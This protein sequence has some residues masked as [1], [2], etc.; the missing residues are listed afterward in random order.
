MKKFTLFFI[1]I[2]LVALSFFVGVNDLTV[3]GLLE[4]V[5]Q[6]RL[7]FMTTRLPRTVSLV[8]AGATMSICGLVMQHLTQNKFVSPTTAGTMDS[9]RLGIVFVMLVLPSASTLTRGFV[10]FV[11]AL[12]GTLAFLFLSRYLPGKS[13]M[14]LP[15][16]GV[17]FG[18]IVG[19]VATFFAYQYQLVQNMSSWLQ[20]NFATVTR[21]SYELLYLTVPIFIV[22]YAFA[23]RFTIIGL[24]EDLAKNLGLNYQVTQFF[25]IFLV[26]IAS[27]VTLIMV[28]TVP[29]L[30]VVVPN[31]VAMIYGDHMKDTL[32][33]T[34]IAGSIFLISCDILSRIIIAPYEIPVSVIVGVIGSVLF[35]FLLLRR[36]R[37]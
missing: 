20:G 29:F 21:G 6:Q 18:N 2:L 25:G 9:A 8:L 27:A 12:L 31:I 37:L 23:Y 1:L 11:F 30:G 36:Q 3:N 17:M 28:G 15:L 14:M 5:G 13:Q 34:A 4:N 16:V 19:S 24:G 7:L 26:A 35:I 33:L 10:A 22:I 32:G